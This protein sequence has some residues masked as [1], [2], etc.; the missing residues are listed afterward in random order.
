MTRSKLV[1]T[2]LGALAV[3]ASLLSANSVLAR[4]SIKNG[5]LAHYPDACPELVARAADC[6]LCH[7]SDGF[8]VNGYGADLAGANE[9]FA[10]IESLDSDG[11]GRTNGQ[12]ILDDCSAPG[13]AVSATESVTWSFIKALF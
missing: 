2:I 1:L 4:N 3:G 7:E 12:E 9:D 6:T 13:D 8:A 10:A 11:D 5:W